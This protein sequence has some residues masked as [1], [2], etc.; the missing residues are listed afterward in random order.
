MSFALLQTLHTPR[1]ACIHTCCAGVVILSAA[2][3]LFLPLPLYHVSYQHF[4]QH[5]L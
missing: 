3:R 5:L 2:Y 1:V 4:D